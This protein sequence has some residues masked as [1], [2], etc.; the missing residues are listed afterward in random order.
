M[1]TAKNN[2]T[3]TLN[4]DDVEDET[5]AVAGEAAF[6]QAVDFESIKGNQLV[7]A[8]EYFVKN[9]SVKLQLSKSGLP[10]FTPRMVIQGGEYDGVPI[11]IDFSWAPNA[12]ARSKR[13]FLGMGMPADFR[14]TLREM[15]EALQD[16]EYYVV[17]DIEQSD[18]VN[19][20][21]NMPYEP[22]NRVVSTSQEPQTGG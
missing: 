9:A 14:G 8:G 6:D 2:V 3:R 16:L 7:P 17:F 18:G 19:E 22:K 12:Q 5:G 1:A 4:L 11:F 21:T 13:H 15:G 10:K 20:R